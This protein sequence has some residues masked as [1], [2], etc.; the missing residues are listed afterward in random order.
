MEKWQIEA[1]KQDKAWMSQYKKKSKKK[2]VYKKRKNT[3]NLNPK[4]KFSGRAT[5]HENMVRGVLIE[6]GIDHEFQK[7]V[8]VNRKKYILDFYFN[9]RKLCVEID[10]FHHFHD[11][12]KSID[13]L[14]TARLNKNGIDVLRF[15]N[16]EVED[17]IHLVLW[18]I[19]KY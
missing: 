3:I 2:P 8:I 1:N 10:G 14:R 5:K 13:R 9:D 7:A 12:Q 18:T 4:G 11:P 6:K 17:D 15:T 16:K 19:L